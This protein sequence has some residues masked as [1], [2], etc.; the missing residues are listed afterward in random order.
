ME[1]TTLEI[2]CNTEYENTPVNIPATVNTSPIE[3]H[4]NYTLDYEIRDITVYVDISHTKISDLQVELISPSGTP[5]VLTQSGTCSDPTINYQDIQV[6]FDDYSSNTIEC[7]D[8]APAVRDDVVPY[9][10]LSDFYFEN[11]MGDWTLSVSDPVDGNGGSI[12]L[13]ALEICEEVYQDPNNDGIDDQS[14]DSFK[15]WPNPS[16]GQINISLSAGKLIPGKIDGY[17]RQRS[18]QPCL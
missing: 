6:I 7:Y 4:I 2:N 8:T 13:W 11:A 3:S 16:N 18:I 15:I 14:I 5:V 12:N 17:F 9:E 10:S 1:F